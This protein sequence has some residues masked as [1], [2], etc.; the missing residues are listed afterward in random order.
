MCLVKEEMADTYPWVD[1]FA[2]MT[3]PAHMTNDL[4]PDCPTDFHIDALEFVSSLTENQYAGALYD[5][6]YSY[7]QASE[8]YKKFG[9]EHLTGTVTNNA[10]YSQV[11]DILGLL[12]Q[13]DGKAICCGWNTNGLGKIR[14]FELERIL[15]VAHGAGHNDSLVTV[16][17][18]VQE[19]LV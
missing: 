19:S 12:I 14:G 6:P 11:K 17:R 7:R 5:P 8:S 1:P 2:G 9:R 4:N 15:V 18:K 3:S 13:A 10:Y 16:E